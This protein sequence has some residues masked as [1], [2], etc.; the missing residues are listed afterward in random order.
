LTGGLGFFCW[1]PAPS[2]LHWK[3]NWFSPYR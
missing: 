2:R 3:H 1:L